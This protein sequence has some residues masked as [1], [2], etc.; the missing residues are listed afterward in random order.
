MRGKLPAVSQT[1]CSDGIGADGMDIY[2]A[3]A[4]G[5]GVRW[6]TAPWVPLGSYAGAKLSDLPVVDITGMFG[7]V[8]K[9]RASVLFCVMP[10]QVPK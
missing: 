7:R 8:M 2:C 10:S 6:L 1:A 5:G 3:S 9:D 4:W